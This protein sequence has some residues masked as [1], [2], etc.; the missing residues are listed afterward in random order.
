MH[1]Y[2]DSFV[3]NFF[4]RYLSSN[5]IC[6]YIKACED[7]RH[8]QDFEKWKANIL[9]DKPQNVTNATNGKKFKVL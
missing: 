7:N 6:T 4:A 1:D 9:V 2:F 5:H 3:E 8:K